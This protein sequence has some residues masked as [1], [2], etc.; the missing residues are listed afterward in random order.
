MIF[1]FDV[2]AAPGSLMTVPAILPCHSA[3]DEFRQYCDLPPGKYTLTIFANYSHKGRTVTPSIYVD[4]AAL[5]RFDH[6]WTAY[7]FDIIPPDNV[8]IDGRPGDA[9][10]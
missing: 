1:P 7:D 5:S 10:G 4:E 6:A 9:G 2:E 8:F 3:F